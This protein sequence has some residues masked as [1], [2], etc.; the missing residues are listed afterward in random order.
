[1]TSLKK[2]KPLVITFS[3]FLLVLTHFSGT[4]TGDEE[5]V[6]NFIDSFLK[7][8]SDL[9]V[10]LNNPIENC[11]IWKK[12]HSAFLKHNL[13]WFFFNLLFYKISEFIF[14][15][16][17]FIDERVLV[18]LSLS[19]FN[20]LLFFVSFTLLYLKFSKK[21]SKKI[22]L[23]TIII[24]IYGTYINNLSSGGYIETIILFLLSIRLIFL[25]KENLTTKDY[26]IISLIDGMLI[27][28]RFFYFWVVLIFFF[29][30]FISKKKISFKL[31]YYFIIIIITL[32][33]FYSIQNTIPTYA[34]L[35]TNEL[36]TLNLIDYYLIKIERSFCVTSILDIITIFSI[37][38]FNSFFSLSVGLFFIFPLIIFTIFAKNKKILIAKYIILLGFIC[39]YSLEQNFYLPAGISGHRGLAPL[40]VMFLPE[41]MEFICM[42]QKKK[43]SKIFLII[44]LFLIFL[45]TPSLYY[46]STLAHYTIFTK[47]FMKN[48]EPTNTKS[49]LITEAKIPR[50]YKPENFTHINLLM[51][52]GILGWKVLIS[53][54]LN[55]EII[56]L[57]SKI[58]EKKI[59]LRDFPPQTL[60]HRSKYLI[61]NNFYNYEDNILKKIIFKYPILKILI[62]LIYYL[63]LILFLILPAVLFKNFFE[64]K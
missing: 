47:S 64:K 15:F 37:R 31:S 40:L 16:K 30:N 18:E 62:N 7:S 42:I 32:I 43:N 45:F 26:I 12:C 59:N 21:Y 13:G 2:I 49:V 35:N 11:E 6:Y 8:N 14:F 63:I 52:P 46:R 29:I 27:C 5:K 54:E 38:V 57:P 19:F 23:A 41:I 55:I 51:H 24:F 36:N 60:L 28:L 22:C 58:G 34:Y 4:V 56:S 50:C 44:G 53:K 17:D 48:N 9:I 61:K 25:Y 3:F 20:T 33:T 1:M 39:A 10:W